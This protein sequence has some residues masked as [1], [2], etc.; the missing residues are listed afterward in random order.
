MANFHI[1]NYD[2]WTYLRCADY[3]K[4]KPFTK[5]GNY[6]RNFTSLF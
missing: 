3:D 6:L 2:N 5:V 4:S 1:A